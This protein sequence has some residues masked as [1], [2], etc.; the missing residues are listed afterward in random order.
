MSLYDDG[1][2]QH[3]E[4]KARWAAASERYNARPKWRVELHVTPAKGYTVHANDADAAHRL[5]E[6]THFRLWSIDKP[7]S[8][9]RAGATI[10]HI[11][12]SVGTGD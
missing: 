5:A 6:A 3:N 12:D 2:E 11:P 1:N 10:T 4:H 7:G 9:F 8:D